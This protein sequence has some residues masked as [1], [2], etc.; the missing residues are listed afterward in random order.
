MTGDW[1]EM[2]MRTDS[3]GNSQMAQEQAETAESSTSF[4]KIA[5][6][7]E[8]EIFIRDVMAG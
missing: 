1:L 7:N 3:Q 2:P 8:S 5:A 4:T 6:E